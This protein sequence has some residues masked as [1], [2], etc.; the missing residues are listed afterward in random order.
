MFFSS[1]RIAITSLGEERNNLSAFH[2]FVRF[3]LV[4]FCLFIFLLVSGKSC[5]LWLW[6]SLVVSLTFFVNSSRILATVRRK[7]I[8]QKICD[9][10]RVTANAAPFWVLFIYISQKPLYSLGC[11]YKVSSRRDYLAGKSSV[12]HHSNSFISSQNYGK[13]KV[14]ARL[15]VKVRAHKITS[16]TNVNQTIYQ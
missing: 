2:T 14:R 12:G 3:A 11:T 4:C 6:H 7:L 8:E 9:S 5:G 13:T 1:F 10:F 15:N 16:W